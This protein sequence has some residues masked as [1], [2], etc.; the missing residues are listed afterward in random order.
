MK[1][2]N[3]FLAG[4]L[5]AMAALAQP[6]P[7]PEGLPQV[8]VRWL[9]AD[10]SDRF[11]VEGARY[12]CR[13][14]LGPARIDA[15]AMDGQNLLPKGLQL[16]FVDEAGDRYV[17]C[18]TGLVPDWDTWQGQKWKPARSAKARMNVWRSSPYYWDAHVLDIPFVRE[19]DLAKAK[20]VD[21]KP[22][23][24]WDFANGVA[25]W[26]GLNQYQTFA[27]KDGALVVGYEGNDP[28]FQ[29][30]PV[31]LPKTP[32]VVVR[33]RLRGSGGGMAV[34]WLE[35]GQAGYD[36]NHVTIVSVGRSDEWH[37]V[38]IPL[39]T[40]GALRQFRL[41]PPGQNGQIEIDRVQI[42]PGAAMPGLKPV[43]GEV[44]FHT[45][46]DRLHMEFRL[47]AQEGR[48]RPVSAHW[49]APT[50]ASVRQVGSRPVLQESGLAVLGVTGAS[51]A[52]DGVWS[53]PLVGE[54]PGCWWVVRPAL[55]DLGATFREELDP[56]PAS[57]VEVR[58]GHWL[59]YDAPSGL[60]LVDSI[61]QGSAYS[62]NTAYDNPLRRQSV[63]IRIQA[64]DRARH[65]TVRAA[66]RAGILPATV[67]ADD[68]G[69]M[70]PTPILSCKNFAGERE[71]P[72]DSAFGEA[73]F[74]VDVPA[75]TTH[76]FQIL[77]VFQNWGN[78]MLQQVTSIRFF[79]I[80]WHLSQGV[81]ETTCFTIPWMRMND[82][83]VRVPDYRPYSGPFWPGQPQHDCRQWPGLLQYRADGKDVHAVY[84]KTVFESIAP[85]MARFTMHFRT[86]DDAA[87]IAMTVTEF[88]QAD[89]MRTFLTVRYEWLKNVAIDG[90]ARR[91]FRWFNVNTLRKPV[92]K[93]MWLDEKGQTQ[94]QDVVPGD[95]PLLGTPLG[96]NAPFLGTHG[97]EGYHAF[98][99]LRRLV[100]QVGGEE[101]TAFASARFR[102]GT[103]DSWFT[104]GKAELAIKAGDT[105]EADLLLMPHAEPT[106]PGAL[107]ERER[108]RY[109]TDGPRVTKVDVGRKLGDFPVHIQAE[110]EAAA[111][112]VEGGHQTTPIIAEGFSHWS[113][114]M[115]WEGSVWLDQQAHG[116]D[117]YQVNPDGKG[118]YRFIFAAPMRHGQTRHWRITR[119]HCTGDIDQVSD[120]NGFP[121]LVSTKGGTF[122]LKA[123]I[124]FAPGTNR[125]QAGSPLIAFAG[126]GKTVR[127]VPI[128]AEAKGEGQVQILRYDETGAEVATT[129]I[130]RL[131]FARLARFATYELMIDGAAR[132]HRVGNNGTLATDLEPGTHRVQFRRAQ[133]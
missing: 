101:L 98:T 88:P 125:L 21:A 42:L 59:G 92:A 14:G 116:G 117:G 93:L 32:S 126:E 114:P 10:K 90:D 112:T 71:E 9:D 133:R 13:I 8:T 128:S 89:E 20:P 64:G 111:F 113:F 23:Q 105:I 4:G 36:G 131:S 102:K 73:Y 44:V 28:Y 70:L 24:T 33:I 52:K 96:T 27:V 120:R 65:L 119:A 67:L 103:S 22:L 55:A 7:A 11:A 41:D 48:P 25:G 62:F 19:A 46:S 115:L 34:Y 85:C 76:S 118:G 80:Y 91:N 75:N 61:A 77:H 109:G 37:E 43:R 3:M 18:P 12:S 106:E 50:S 87:R 38:E 45:Y 82:A 58:N 47:D 97:Q 26:E 2:F 81:S 57:S 124:L 30:P 39:R 130:K 5:V 15:L 84:E 16:G 54:R 110:G 68:N 63:P 129:G 78:H 56:L 132:T 53:A 83:Y 99:L 108:I 1:K 66:S 40:K 94:I 86:S 107:A 100:G 121:E 123:P 104:V 74:P 60:Y 31:S 35:E 95:E 49:L 69:F 127:G 122:T 72:D 6:I 79:H 17:A 29:A 51:F